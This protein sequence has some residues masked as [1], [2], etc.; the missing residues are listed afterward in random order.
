MT[1]NFNSAP[2][3]QAQE[4]RVIPEKT[5]LIKK[6]DIV[7]KLKDLGGI[8]GEN[9]SLGD[10]DQ[11]GELTARKNRDP[12][13]DLYR[14]SGCF[15]RPNYERGLLMYSLVKK[16]QPKSFLEIG[17]GRGYVSLCV[18]LAMQENNFG[19]ITTVDPNF[20]QDHLLRLQNSY[21]KEWFTRINFFQSTSESFFD[22]KEAEDQYDIIFLDGDH[23]Y[24]A[25]KKDWDSTK[26]RFKHV[27]VFDDYHLPE[28]NEK[29]IEVASVVDHISEEYEK[30]LVITDRR[31]FLDDRK[32]E[33]ELKYGMVCVTR[34]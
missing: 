22:S 4:S 11:I 25:V 6:I 10:F 23:R 2:F 24:D 7:D 31:I 21:P 3:F 19:T 29:D 30:E 16:Y 9:L 8:I 5:G 13:S 17:F 28:V 32:L 27:L 1:F 20:N 14:N 33:G 26:E 15:F 34:K 18:A 12:Q